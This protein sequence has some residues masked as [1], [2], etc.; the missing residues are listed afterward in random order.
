MD[1]EWPI[2]CKNLTRLKPKSKQPIANGMEP[3]GSNIIADKNFINSI[4]KHGHRQLK[5]WFGCE[6]IV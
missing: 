4:L 3:S 6:K 2:Y 5:T 1:L